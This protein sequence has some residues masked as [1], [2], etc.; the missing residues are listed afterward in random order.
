MARTG[1]SNKKVKGGSNEVSS[2]SSSSSKRFC[3]STTRKV[4]HTLRPMDSNTTFLLSTICKACERYSTAREDI[5]IG[6]YKDEK[7][8]AFI[9]FFNIEKTAV[10][11]LNDICIAENEQLYM[12]VQDTPILWSWGLQQARKSFENNTIEAN[13]VINYLILTALKSTDIYI[14]INKNNEDDENEVTVNGILYLNDR[15][16]RIMLE[17]LQGYNY[18]IEEDE[19]FV[20]YRIQEKDS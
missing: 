13:E 3:P 2:S 1:F 4:P 14:E 10:Y 19:L 7:Y 9:K 12:P 11:H 16:I 15:L 8:G 18:K 6:F 20:F 5:M 17:I